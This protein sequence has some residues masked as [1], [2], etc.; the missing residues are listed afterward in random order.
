MGKHTKKRVYS[1]EARKKF[2]DAALKRKITPEN[3]KIR[4]NKISEKLKM[5]FSSMDEA[6][7][8]ELNDKIIKGQLNKSECEIKQWRLKQRN[9]RITEMIL[10]GDLD[11]FKPSYNLNAIPF[12]EEYGTE[13]GY[14]FRHALNHTKGEYRIYDSE[15]RKTYYADGYDEKQNVWIEFD[16]S[17]KNSK[18]MEFEKLR[19]S[20][21]E[22]LLNCK[23]IR[24]N[25]KEVSD[26]LS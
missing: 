22:K 12:I 14:N 13:Y 5:Y 16:E 25:E 6:T 19:Q 26:G 1:P 24:L 10:K 15:L 17:K 9:T 20:R 18:R 4:R 23:F 7:R 8:K 3:E 2:S 21:I 11:I